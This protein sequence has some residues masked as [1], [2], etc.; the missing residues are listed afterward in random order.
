MLGFKNASKLQTTSISCNR[1]SAT[2]IVTT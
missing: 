1:I 2:P